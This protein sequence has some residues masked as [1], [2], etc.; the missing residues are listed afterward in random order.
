MRV[1]FGSFVLSV[2][3]VRIYYIHFLGTLKTFFLL[4]R[5]WY[6]GYGWNQNNN[7]SD[8]IKSKLTTIIWCPCWS[9]VLKQQ[10][11]CVSICLI[12]SVVVFGMHLFAFSWLHLL[13][14]KPNL[15]QRLPG[16]RVWLYWL[17]KVERECAG[18]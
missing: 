4:L 8:R 6:R 12:I 17:H 11:I 3:L 13:C 5:H 10:Y 16:D 18:F 2:H 7:D 1:G 15:L 14:E 9:I